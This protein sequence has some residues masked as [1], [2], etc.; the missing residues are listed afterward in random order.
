MALERKTDTSQRVVYTR[1]SLHWGGQQMMAHRPNL[2]QPVSVPPMI[3]MG[4]AFLNG[5]KKFKSISWC[6]KN[7]IKFQFQHL[8][9]VLLEHYHVHYF[10]DSCFHTTAAKLSSW[11][12]GC[13]Q[14]SHHFA[15]VITQQHFKYHAFRRNFKYHAFR[16]ITFYYF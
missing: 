6:I 4:S 1:P 8:W 9:I 3:I 15:V 14:W 16:H 10:T 13:M 12:R 7:S 5:W 11:N 2:A